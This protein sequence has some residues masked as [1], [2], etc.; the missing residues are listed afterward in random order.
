MFNNVFLVGAQKSGTSFLCSLLEQHPSLFLPSNLEPNY[1]ALKDT[2]QKFS[3]PGD[4]QTINR[5]SIIVERDYVHLFHKA[6]SHQLCFDCSTLYLYDEQAPRQI[7]MQFPQ[8]KIIAVLRNPA[9]RAYSAFCHLRRDGREM[10]KDFTRALAKEGSRIDRG[11]EFLWHYKNVGYYGD[12]LSRYY[13]EF[14]EAN[15]KVLLFEELVRNPELVLE[16]IFRF[17]NVHPV[18]KLNIEGKIN[19]SGIPKSKVINQI[20]RSNSPI[21]YLVKS[22]VPRIW[23]RKI[24][25]SINKRNL[26][27]KVPL[28]SKIRNK[29]FECYHKDI[30]LL[31]KNCGI[32]FSRWIEY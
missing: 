27:P 3:G 31:S 20:I 7:R 23:L 4:F 12:Q 21:K 10:E 16:D 5:S 22:V 15:I 8:A 32:D 25:G 2:G 19:S 13:H 1:W 29:L 9:D 18:K 30:Q 24:T 17:L 26:I 11:Y 28:E 14:P 6:R